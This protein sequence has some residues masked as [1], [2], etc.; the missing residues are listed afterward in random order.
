MTRG[1][2]GRFDR[3]SRRVASTSPWTT[4][5]VVTPF[6]ISAITTA[7]RLV[8]SQRRLGRHTDRVGGDDEHDDDGQLPREAH[9]ETP[10]PEVIGAAEPKSETLARTIRERTHQ[11]P[12]WL[13]RVLG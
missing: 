3:A 2:T 4:V 12:R 5:N 6:A 7:P 1:P 8:A 9:G 13:Q 10:P 11:R